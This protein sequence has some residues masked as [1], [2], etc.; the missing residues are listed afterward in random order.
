MKKVLSYL[1]GMSIIAQVVI[2][3]IRPSDTSWK[4][5]VAVYT[6]HV[7]MLLSGG[8]LFYLSIQ[9]KTRLWLILFGLIFAGFFSCVVSWKFTYVIFVKICCFL[10]MV[11]APYAAREIAERGNMLSRLVHFSILLSSIG[12]MYLYSLNLE[13][14]Y[15][16]YFLGQNK[17]QSGVLL[18][19][20]FFASI[21]VLLTNKRETRWVYLPSSIILG[22]L[23]AISRCRTAM[24]LALLYIA[25][26][27]IGSRIVLSKTSMRAVFSLPAMIMLLLLAFPQLN[28]ASLFGGTGG[29]LDGRE[30]IYTSILENVKNWI[31][32]GNL[33]TYA[34]SNAHNGTLTIAA[35]L[36]II[37]LFI[38]YKGQSYL[39]EKMRV[40]NID[41]KDF[42][43][44]APYIAIMC[45]LLSA[46]TEAMIYVQGQQVAIML[47]I[48]VFLSTETTHKPYQK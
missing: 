21:S 27:L 29:L 34:F 20:N 24:L 7:C 30:L 25:I 42:H 35:S 43:Y 31:I 19:L 12:F 17:N 33:G 10:E 47:S 6:I 3:W 32:M 16:V 39:Y 40:D 26:L 5:T 46:A 38:W 14:Y 45:C 4:M 13:T 28:Q 8:I 44:C 22:G 23:I 15:S 1:Y 11:I 48:L 37:G 2:C 18:L 9:R 36:G 41:L